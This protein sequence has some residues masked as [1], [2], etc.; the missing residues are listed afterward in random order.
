LPFY[1]IGDFDFFNLVKM[2]VQSTYGRGLCVLL[3]NQATLSGMVYGRQL[4]H[5][6][7]KLQIQTT[8]HNSI[9]DDKDY[10]YDWRFG[11]HLKLILWN[12][13]NCCNKPTAGSIG[14]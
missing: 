1:R 13:H 11:W 12:A 9:I 10:W 5:W 14:I 3:A 2:Y 4:E 7:Q 8:N 6:E